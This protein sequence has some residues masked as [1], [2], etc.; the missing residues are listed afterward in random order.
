MVPNPALPNPLNISAYEGTCTHP[1][2]PDLRVSSSCSEGEGAIQGLQ[3]RVPDLCVSIVK[4]NQ[5]AQYLINNLFHVSGTFWI[6]ISTRWGASKA[7]R[8]EFRIDSK[9]IASWL[10]I[11]IKPLMPV[12]EKIWWKRS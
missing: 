7:M 3:R 8:V 6:Q 10:G 4:Y 1:A 5:Y 11:E 2:Y 12:R 9:G